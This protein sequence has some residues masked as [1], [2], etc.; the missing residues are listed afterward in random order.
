LWNKENRVLI[1]Y[2]NAVPPNA[3]PNINDIEIKEMVAAL[4][5]GIAKA[6]E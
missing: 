5:A 1:L 6:N 3:I 2:F 4:R